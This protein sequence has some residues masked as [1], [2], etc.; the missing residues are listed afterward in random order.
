MHPVIGQ[1]GPL[2]IYSYGLMLAVAFLLSVFLI[3]REAQRQGLNAAKIVDLALYLIIFG[4]VGARVFY[5]LLNLE[6]YLKNPLEII[7]LSHG[8][9]VFYGGLIVATITGLWFVKKNNLPLLKVADIFALYLPLA[10]AIGRVGCLLNGCCYGKTTLWPWGLK[11]PGHKGNVHPTQVYEAIFLVFIF[12]ILKFFYRKSKR[13]GEVFILYFLLY[14]LGRFLLEF[15]RGDNPSLIGPFTIFQ[16]ISLIIFTVSI[17][18]LI[19][20]PKT[21]E[22]L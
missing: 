9:L 16:I 13:P 20:Q 21:N 18:F 8:G 5:V 12:L 6:E 4:I 10:Q 1:I 3:K 17:L 14:S 11:L 19:L 2:T 22:K 15:Y 7:M